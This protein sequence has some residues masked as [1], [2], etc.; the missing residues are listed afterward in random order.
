MFVVSRE[1]TCLS[2]ILH[3]AVM[4]LCT[5]TT[6]TCVGAVTTAGPAIDVTGYHGNTTSTT[7]S[8]RSLSDEMPDEQR[9]L[10][11]LLRS[12]DPGIRP[13]FNVSQNIVVNFSLTLVQIMDMVTCLVSRSSSSKSKSIYLNKS[14]DTQVPKDTDAR[15]TKETRNMGQSPT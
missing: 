13:V 10:V 15:P 1:E 9:L 14:L 7:S 11:K 4:I 12:Y 2:F 3:V 6:V 5:V 8:S